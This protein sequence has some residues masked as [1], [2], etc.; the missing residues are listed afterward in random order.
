[1]DSVVLLLI[2]AKP[3]LLELMDVP[4]TDLL[5]VVVTQGCQ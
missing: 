3:M 5:L 2:Q 4:A 1:M